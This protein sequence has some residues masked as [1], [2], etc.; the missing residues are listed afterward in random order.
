MAIEMPSRRWY[1]FRYAAPRSSL[2]TPHRS[3]KN[4]M[5]FKALSIS[6]FVGVV[7]TLG[8]VFIFNGFRVT[9]WS[10]GEKRFTF[11]IKENDNLMVVEAEDKR[12]AHIRAWEGYDEIS[13]YR[14]SSDGHSAFSVIQMSPDGLNLSL[15]IK[16]D[17]E[18]LT[19]FDENGDGFFERLVKGYPMKEYEVSY[20]VSPKQDSNQPE[21]D[22]PITRP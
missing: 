9:R 11:N 16:K 18:E 17:G 15:L 12:G 14:E 6:F 19:F 13:A 4:L 21:Q 3:R 20:T 2:E 1:Q 5:N 22:N 10:P 8:L 7:L